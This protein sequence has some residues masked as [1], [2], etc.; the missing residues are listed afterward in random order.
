VIR[1]IVFWGDPRLL[2][3]NE[4]VRSFDGD[5]R[6]LIDDLVGT[7]HAAPGLGLAAPQIGVNRS[8]AIVDLS[9]GKNPSEVIVMV[10]PR[11]L[12]C[13]GAVK[14]SEGCLSV[15]GFSA[16]VARPE[17]VTV[18]AADESGTI[19]SISGEGLLARALC[20]EID[21]LNATLYFDHL[22]GLGRELLLRKVRKSLPLRRAA[23]T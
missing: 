5:V 23:T 6:A 3:P 13:G 7:C 11:V 9:V 20:H 19:R 10:N 15:P 21:H 2:A 12:E 8:V 17:R 1:D 14:S 18:E 4:A 22:R 16:S